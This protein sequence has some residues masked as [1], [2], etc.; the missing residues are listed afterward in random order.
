[1]TNHSTLPKLS[2]TE[3]TVYGSLPLIAL[4]TAVGFGLAFPSASVAYAGWPFVISLFVIGMPH[5]AVDLWITRRINGNLRW[6]QALIAFLGYCFLMAVVFALLVALPKLT[7]LAFAVISALHFGIADVHSL[8]SEAATPSRRFE[9]FAAIARGSLILSLPFAFWPA[10]SWQTVNQ[11]QAIVGKSPTAYDA[12]QSSWI[13]SLVVA[14]ALLLQVGVSWLRWSRG[15]FAFRREVV[16]TAVLVLSFAT[17]HPLFAMGLYVLAWHSWRHML[18]LSRFFNGDEPAR[19]FA[20]VARSILKMHVFALPLLI[21]TWVIF[22]G[23]AWWR[24]PT[25][26][27]ASIAAMTIAFYVVVTLP[28]HLLVERLFGRVEHAA[29]DFR[30]NQII[31]AMSRYPNETA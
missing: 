18:P 25:W 31:A 2:K 1:M 24:L 6:S 20:E 22:L 17:L 11:I 10:A 5:G 4:I 29:D 3:R 19:G 16:E 23:L 7:L 12:A 13:A 28:H 30:A 15:D 26:D 27:A 9:L 21:P 14:V 8:R